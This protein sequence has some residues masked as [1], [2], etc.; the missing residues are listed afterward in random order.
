MGDVAV[1]AARVRRAA[2]AVRAAG[3]PPAAYY[4]EDAY[5]PVVAV[6]PPLP[7]EPPPS[8]EPP[9]PPQPPAPRRAYVPPSNA[10]MERRRHGAEQAKKV[11]NVIKTRW[12]EEQDQW[13]RI[14][15]FNMNDLEAIATDTCILREELRREEMARVEAALRAATDAIRDHEGFEFQKLEWRREQLRG[16]VAEQ[17]RLLS[18]RRQERQA[19]LRELDERRREIEGECAAIVRSLSPGARRSAAMFIRASLAGGK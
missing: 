6:Q 17:Q 13:L 18:R 19:A 4:G 10:L 1:R 11:Q 2:A 16:Q 15:D 7:P 3:G 12:R 8:S 14:H 5:G 9:L